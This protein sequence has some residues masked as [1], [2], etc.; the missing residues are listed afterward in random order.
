VDTHVLVWLF[1]DPDRLSG[2]A[3]ATIESADR[4]LISPITWWEIA[5]LARDDRIRL[6]RPIGHWISLVMDDARSATA[7]LT[8]EAAAWAG[9]LGRDGFPGD[10]SDRMIYA[11]ARE[12]RVPLVSKDDRLHRHA[13]RER[14]VDV[15]W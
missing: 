2:R 7:P 4:V 5:L 12:L 6:D 13:H 9:G 10:P 11:T 14:D 8:P 1:G 15:V 3:L